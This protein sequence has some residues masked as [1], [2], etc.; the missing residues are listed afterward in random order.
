M[1][2]NKAAR[3]QQPLRVLY[4]SRS[5]PNNVIPCLGLWV[6]GLVRHSVEFCESK[7]ISPVP[8]CPP[9]PGLGQEYTRFRRVE[10]RRHSGGVEI[11]HPRF[12]VPPGNRFHEFESLTYYMGVVR[13]ADG[14]R[15][16][17]R[18]NLI[19]AHFSYPDGWV[20]A[21]LGKRY[22][23][24]VIIT[25]HAPW[26]PWMEAYP[27]V[28][29]QARWAF[30]ECAFHIGVSSI[31][32]DEVAYFMGDSTKTRIIPCG[33]DDSI[34]TLPCAPQRPRKQILFA[35]A[36]RRI[37]GVD[38]LLRAMRML[39]DRGHQE[40]LV[41]VGDS[42]YRA[43]QR[44][45]AQVRQMML[46]LGLGQ[47][48]EFVGG[49]TQP[50]LARH[51]QESAV[52][53]LPSRKE[54]LGMVL[55]EALACGTPVVAT[56]CGGPEDI[57]NDQVGVLVPPEDPASLANA[58]EEVIDHRDHYEPK[59]LRDYALERFSWER[60]TERYLDLYREAAAERNIQ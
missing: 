28:L 58:I 51:M 12:L 35:G 13:S 21:R 54:S 37:K 6:E 7:V 60:I 11:L 23:V 38:I 59:F 26:R 16:N 20:A 4:L 15:R 25:E 41:L 17:F 46:D 5:Y 27:R 36:I 14:L 18:F 31:V 52:L 55:I 33:V 10:Q 19:H 43:Y 48:V 22:G 50:E 56:R 47:Q 8:Y 39:V 30:N 3:S 49:K 42:Y 45:Y 53:V 9:F 44:D 1:P 32:R 57:V 2:E 29:R 40:K 34:F 24:P